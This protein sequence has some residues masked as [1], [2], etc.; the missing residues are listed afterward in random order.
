MPEPQTLCLLPTLWWEG[1]E[2]C[3]SLTHRSPRFL[4]WV[5][6]SRLGKALP[7]SGFWGLECA[8]ILGRTTGP[9]PG[10]TLSP[11]GQTPLLPGPTL[12]LEGP[13]PSWAH[14]VCG[15][16]P[17]SWTHYVP[18]A[19]CLGPTLSPVP[20]VLGPLCPQSP[21]PGVIPCIW[22]CSQQRPLRL[23]FVLICDQIGSE[24]GPDCQSQDSECSGHPPS[25]SCPLSAR[26][27]GP[28]LFLDGLRSTG[29]ALLP[30]GLGFGWGKEMATESP[31]SSRG[32]P[33]FSQL[34][35]SVVRAGWQSWG[36]RVVW[37]GFPL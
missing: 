2:Q 33:W 23:A 28:C 32:N 4:I 21:C 6:P 8:E 34:Q 12:S 35:P 16:P 15:G 27:W 9:H 36:P 31:E 1:S 20:A 26:V 14:S 24:R 25:C 37:E 10:L 13:P 3:G 22:G 11:E 5:R 18:G 29:S 19:S 30:M 17:P 7:A